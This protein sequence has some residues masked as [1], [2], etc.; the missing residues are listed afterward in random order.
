MSDAT[1]LAAAARSS[2]PG[3][4]AL[5]VPPIPAGMSVVTRI[6]T[7]AANGGK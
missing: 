6:D 2:Q 7:K 3:D 4:G 5:A 1:Q